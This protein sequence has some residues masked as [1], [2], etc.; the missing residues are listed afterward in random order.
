M[1]FLL[2]AASLAYAREISF[3]PV[4][5][6]T[7]SDQLVLGGNYDLDI[8]QARFA[9]LTTYA[10]LPYVHCLAR[11][12]EEVEKYD[13]AVLGAPFDTVSGRLH[14]TPST[15]VAARASTCIVEAWWTSWP[16]FSLRM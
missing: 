5:G 4:S 13:I 15:V 14:A 16:R 9:G 1:K 7:T 3:P 6:Y 2:L 11:D 10:N 12:G 8:S